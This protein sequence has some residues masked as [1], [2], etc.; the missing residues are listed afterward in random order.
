MEQ[1][2]R[3]LDDQNQSEEEDKHQT[4]GFQLQIFFAD[5]H[6]E[7][8]WLQGWLMVSLRCNRK[9]SFGGLIIIFVT[10]PFSR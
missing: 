3:E 9:F 8:I 4:D 5:V 6:L 1:H 2:G 10:C 7:W